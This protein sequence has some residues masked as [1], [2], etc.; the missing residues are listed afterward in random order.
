MKTTSNFKKIG[1]FTDIHF[2]RRNNSKIHNQDCIDF[3]QW[4]C[5]QVSNGDYS[6][7]VFLG[8][9][10][11]SR[12]AIN[13]ET[14][15]FSYKALQ[16]LNELNLPIY[17][18]VGNHD[19]HKRTT[20][21]VHSVRMFNELSNFIVID[22]ITVID[23]ILFS[24]FLFEEEYSNLIKHNNL[25][26]WFGHFE[27]KNFILT[28]NTRVA[29]H[30]PDHNLFSGPKKIF[31]G[32]FHKR[33][34]QNNVFYIGNAFPMDFGDA[35]DY[36]RGMCTYYKDEDKVTFTNWSDCPKYYKTTLS[37]VINE[38]WKPLPKMR[39]KCIID[40][41]L[42]YQDAIDL[43][44]SMISVYTLRDFIIEEDRAIKQGLLEGD[45]CRIDETIAEFDSI[46]DLIIK[47]LETVKEDKKTNING[48]MLVNIYKSL[49]VETID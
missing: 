28:G 35:S 23:D 18:C 44:D 17:F 5:I 25:H 37:D 31:S 3:I 46:D 30:G 47:Q 38:K 27:F 33:Q 26:A 42:G 48:S 19:L 12:S 20:R 14:L 40:S 45:D 21:D 7:I 2:G 24:P 22:K 16:M 29:E 36:E 39:V 49:T 6:H 1:M 13:I 9:W 41:D 11:E 34:N 4:F 32:H 10:F 8:D 15:E 43:R